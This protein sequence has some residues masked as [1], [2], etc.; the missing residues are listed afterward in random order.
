MAD[1]SAV[2]RAFLGAFIGYARRFFECCA[3]GGFFDRFMFFADDF[4]IGQFWAGVCIARFA[5]A[6]YLACRFAF[7][8]GDFLGHFAVDG[9]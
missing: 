6:A 9:R 5:F 4:G 8:L 1:R 7:L 2:L 3:A